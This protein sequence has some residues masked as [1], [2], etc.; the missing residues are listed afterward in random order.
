[1]RIIINISLVILLLSIV[2][3]VDARELEFKHLANNNALPSPHVN[4]ITQLRQGFMLVS[5]TS[6]ARL[7][8]G[9]KLIEFNVKNPPAI[10]PLNAN[11]YTALEDS[12]GN[13]WFATSLGLYKLTP[14]THILKRISHDPLNSNSLLDDNVRVIIEDLE[15]NLWFG[16]FSGVSRLNPK[17]K[18]FTHFNAK[19]L[20]DETDALIG[21][22]RVLIQLN[23]EKIW[24][25]SSEGL[26]D[27][28]PKTD[29]FKRV[30]GKIGQA[31]ITSALITDN[32]QLWLGSFGDGVFKLDN[33]GASV[34]NLRQSNAA[35]YGIRSDEIWRLYQ[36]HDK[37]IW[38]GYWDKGLSVY[39][40]DTGEVFQGVYRQGL[41]SSLPNKYISNIF[42]DSSGL[43][44]IASTTGIAT[45]NP[46][47][48]NIQT[49]SHLPNDPSSIGNGMIFAIEESANNKIWLGTENG[50]ERW[51]RQDNRI[52]HFYHDANDDSSITAG[53]IWDLQLVG[54]NYLLA[55]T[56]NGMDLL[57]IASGKF[58]HFRAIQAK[59]SKAIASAFYT[60]VEKSSQWFYVTGT[61]K[62]VFLFN[63]LSGEQ[64][65][66]F[67]AADN[68]LTNDVEYFTSLLV[69]KRGDLWLGST[70][71]LYR[72]NMTT[73]AVTV[74][75]TN[76]NIH[77]LSDN[78]IYGLI[79]VDDAIWVATGNGG[80][81]KILTNSD[82]DTNISYI[83]KQQGLPSNRI[84]SLRAGAN[85]QLWFVSHQHFGAIN[86][87]SNE[88]SSYSNLNAN[89]LGYREGAIKLGAD[90]SIY[91]G[92]SRLRRFQPEILK[93]SHYQPLVR[94]TGV[95]HLH[96]PFAGFSPLNNEQVIE[97]NPLDTL[98]TFEFSSLDFASPE[99][100]QYRYQLVGNDED[101]LYPGTE[102]KAYYTHLPAGQYQLKVQGTNRD[103]LWSNK[104]ASLNIVMHPAFY[105]SY[106]AYF[107]YFF[108]GVTILLL[109]IRVQKNKRKIELD[110]LQKIK[111]SEARLRDVLWGSGD[112]LWRWN[113]KL[114]KIYSTNTANIESSRIENEID[115]DLLMSQVHSDDQERI[116]DRLERH[117]KGAED[118]YEA[119]YRI[120]NPSTNQWCWM[121]SRGRI[122]EFDK[123]GAPLVIAGTRKNID[124]LKKT[125]KQLRYLADYDQLTRLP[126]RALFHQHLKH[127]I[128]MAKRFSEK[129]ALLYLDLD[130]FK[131]VN[132]TQGHAVGDQLLQAV[133]S[134]L[135]KLL[136][137]TDRCSRLGGDEFAI[138]IERVQFAEEVLPTLDR[139]LA[140]LAQPFLLNGQKV[141]TSASVGVAIYPDHAELPSELLKYADFAMYEAKRN[142]KKGYRFYNEEMNALFMQRISI[143]HELKVAIEENQFE[144]F[145]QPRVSVAD[146]SVDGFEALVRWRHPKRGL[147][148]PGEF[149]PIA[150]ETGQILA[151]GEW[152]L[153]DGCQQGALWYQQGWRGFV[154]INIAALQFQQSDLVENVKSALAKSNL[155]A[156][157]LELEITESTLIKDIDMTCNVLL[158]LKNMGVKISLDDFGTGYSSLSYLQQLPID[159]LKID[160][161]FINL[162]PQS[163]KSVRLCT[164]II[165]MAHSLHLMVVAEGIEEEAQLEFLRTLECQQYQG[166]LFAK[167]L[168][169][170]EIA[171]RFI[172]DK[173]K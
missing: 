79:E 134:R 115:F 94:V 117:I 127:A 91:L 76:E 112:V 66:V 57:D 167:P 131:L 15:H 61:D 24:L 73:K 119:Q 101:W 71:G 88:I 105:R 25:G 37:K 54:E 156:A 125:E 62:S 135:T 51:D 164:A 139:L 47:N 173:A 89:E 116:R 78:H 49:V 33:A 43:V 124:D 48:F 7:F 120:T 137:S 56:N 30:D 19:N 1:V 85:N 141:T 45:F 140:E 53:P 123:K 72:V 13:I 157:C 74:Y 26:F 93:P 153:N 129:V 84:Y 41:K 68:E 70:T 99:L 144:T 106:W 9:K 83:T 111:A 162:I 158:K 168:P 138:I 52:K 35:E 122:V 29:V 102:N 77:R 159:A 17:L 28:N 103:G 147:V 128:D 169:A 155:P 16:T 14:S 166:F 11:I 163:S 44:W 8:D 63:P 148:S 96:K 20:I 149:I 142:A 65:L 113:I 23:D 170:S 81:N 50:I 165:N 171:K 55:A 21:I 80:I 46:I 100:N 60:I 64:R 92:D 154:S 110:N 133:S 75:A 97:L 118:Y 27:I 161:A 108:S 40:P 136:R 95:S 5:T 107:I 146:N 151:I 2:Y 42:G 98:V 145:F 121:L 172:I 59:P 87:E 6:G 58:T 160:R 104:V 10:S 32:K 114:N 18:R 12:A 82:G 132:D 86:T 3:S 150:E 109:I 90:N 4:D 34:I 38:I 31:H 143:E 69:S 39:D 126:N 152:V 130:G 36:G 22:P 67:D